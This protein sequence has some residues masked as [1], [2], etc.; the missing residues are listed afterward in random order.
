V[1]VWG[2]VVAGEGVIGGEGKG[3]PGSSAAAAPQ[4]QQEGGE[5]APRPP[6]DRIKVG[7][8]EKCSRWAPEEP[9]KALNMEQQQH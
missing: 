5:L 1:C 8:S 9:S 7:A 6:P 3:C 2:L 4:Q